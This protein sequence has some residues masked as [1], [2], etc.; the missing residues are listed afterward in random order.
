MALSNLILIAPTTFSVFDPTPKQ[1]LEQNK[2]SIIEN[3]EGRKLSEKEVIALAANCVGVIAGTEK[4]SPHVLESLPNLK[5]I[6]RVGV[7]I[8]NIDLKVA[9]EMGIKVF[10]TPGGPTLPVAELTVGL[11]LNLLRKV[12]QMDRALRRGSWKKLMGNLLLNK[13]VGI[14]GFGSIGQKTG[15]LL[16]AFGAELSYCDLETKTCSYSCVKKNLEEIIDWADIITIHVSSSDRDGPIIGEKELK[17]MKKDAWLVNA[18]RGGV[19]DEGA[20]YNALQEGHI[21]GAAVDV[22][23]KEPYDGALKELDN[24]ILTPHIGSYAKEARIEMEIQSVENLLKGL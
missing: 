12:Q 20:L 2:Y 13:K 9:E 18:S 22:F 3:K 10:N 4:Y 5:V 11:I 14:I 21:A 23:D 8:D 1:L 17:A 7:G 19:V 24:V 16:N 15:E 6:S